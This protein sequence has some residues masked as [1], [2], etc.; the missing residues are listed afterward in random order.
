MPPVDRALAETAVV[1]RADLS[2]PEILIADDDPG[3]R[4]LLS[5]ALSRDFRVHLAAD[6]LAALALLKSARPAAVIMDEMMPGLTGTQVLEHA[7]ALFPNVP[8]I[9]MTAS[10]DTQK[11]VSAV[12]SGE[13]HRFY[14]KPLRLMDVRRAV[15]ELVQRARERETLL[16]ELS[17]L[18]RV[19]EATADARAQPTH[20]LIVGGAATPN[21]RD[22]INAACVARGFVVTHVNPT[23]AFATTAATLSPDVV[24][25]LMTP[26]VDVAALT[27]HA[28]VLDEATAV[29]VV[30]STAN[31]LHAL[32][33]LDAGASDY[34]A[35]KPGEALTV[36]MVQRRME[37]AAARPR[38]QR[39]LRRVTYDLIVSNRE[40]TVARKRVESEQ[41]KLLNA[42]IRALEARDAYT[43]GHTDRV[44]DISIRCGQALGMTYDQLE[45]LR[46]GALLH[47]IGKIGVRDE[48]LLK[49]SR[50]TPEEFE[51][52]KTHTSIG[53]SLLEGIEQFACILP[54]VRN[55][56]EKLDGTGY[57]DGLA[58][59]DV[60]RE[61]RVVS[62][63]DVL[64][65][66]TSTRP[67]RRGSSIEEAFEII[68]SAVHKQHL[69]GDVVGALKQVHA[70]GRLIEL[71]QIDAQTAPGPAPYRD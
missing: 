30:E 32:I 45:I 8:R 68:N 1:G 37:R 13:I 49:P 40:L 20:V 65:A 14:T 6:G 55:H 61:V 23:S 62:A 43:A 7:K 2:A 46:V 35:P 28:H 10:Q 64:D 16:S 52:I 5:R 66:L 33:A 48:V 50:L 57:P 21:E 19:N 59:D 58:G 71:L 29:V 22:L 70:E 42:M 38:A 56:H 51:V 17:T 25:I 60:P 54:V 15:L 11:A 26:G 41:V 53:A 67:Y 63:S 3:L 47:D 24:A 44:A 18:R 69:D 27:H 31:A 34:I 4:D 39:D 9:L 12:N 36:A